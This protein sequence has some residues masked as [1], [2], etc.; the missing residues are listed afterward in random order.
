[1]ITPPCASFIFVTGAA[2]FVVNTIANPF[3]TQSFDCLVVFFAW[4]QRLTTPQRLVGKRHGVESQAV[5]DNSPLS[6]QTNAQIL[7]RNTQKAEPLKERNPL[8]DAK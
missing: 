3:P 8:S 1:M 5:C 4:H 2:D 6:Q 7:A